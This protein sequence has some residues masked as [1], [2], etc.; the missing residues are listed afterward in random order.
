M[1]AL[2]YFVWA[3]NARARVCVRVSARVTHAISD[4]PYFFH[5]EFFLDS[6]LSGDKQ[7]K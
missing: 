5:S 7:E 3:R 1:Y 6:V 4:I 2:M